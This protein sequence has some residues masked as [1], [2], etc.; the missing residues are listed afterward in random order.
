M[1]KSR[2]TN[3]TLSTDYR[4]FVTDL[5]SRI[6]SARLSAARR[7]NS[8]LVTLYWDIGRGIVE[9]QK[10]LN[11]GE[12]V[13]EMVAAD[14]RAAFP[15]MKGF[16]AR[17]IWDMK[18]LYEAYTTPDFL[19]QVVRAL[20]KPT[21]RPI[22]P[23]AVA[24]LG[25]GEKWRQAVAN[26]KPTEA[27]QILPQLVAEIP[28]GH[29]RFLLDKVTA[30]AAR[31]WYLRATASFGWSRNVLLNQIKAAAYERAVTEKKTHNF[32]LALPEHFAEQAEEMLKSSYNLEFL[33]L[34]RA[35]RERQLEDR[36]ISRL[37]AFLLEL[38]YGFCFVGRQHRLVLGKKEYF[39]DLLFYHRFL[40]ALVAFE[41]KLG[42]FE[43]EFAGKMDFYLNLLNDTERAPGDQPS[44][45][46]IL[47]AEKDDVEVEYALRTK[48]NPI[49]V[50]AY[51][52]QSKL[53]GELKGRLPT[54][55]QL[56]DMIRLEME[57]GK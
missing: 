44:I 51:T 41:L 29:H 47:C 57:G 8:E 31:L 11:W 32:D 28:W 20:A 35:V 9:K 30:P 37:Q 16:S 19:S 42:P 54:A 50:A 18:R 14:L 7:V 33:G 15:D 6:A 23:Q 52:L 39:I 25:P 38:G 24:E 22:L 3:L 49:G 21:S 55:K 2:D 45:G 5:K 56:A 43:P 53:P 46:I 26:L 17:N 36:L 40:K 12:S 4:Q 34:R 27:V 1:K 48:A 10:E 13:V